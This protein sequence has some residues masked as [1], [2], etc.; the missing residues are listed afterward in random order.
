MRSH[1]AQLSRNGWRMWGGVTRNGREETGSKKK[2]REKN[3]ETLLASV[4]SIQSFSVGL[5]DPGRLPHYKLVAAARRSGTGRSAAARSSRGTAGRSGRSAAL[6]STDVAGRS[7]RSAAAR[8]RSAAGRGSRAAALGSAALRE[9][10]QAALRQTQ[11]ELRTAAINHTAG[12]PAANGATRSGAGRSSRG[13]ASRGSGCTAGRSGRSTAARRRGAAALLPERVDIRCDTTHH[14]SGS[15][16]HPL[17]S[18]HLLRIEIVGKARARGNLL[19]GGHHGQVKPGPN[20]LHGSHDRAWES[21]RRFRLA[22]LS[23]TT[24]FGPEQGS[25]PGVGPVVPSVS[26]LT[27]GPPTARLADGVQSPSRS[28]LSDTVCPGISF[29]IAVSLVTVLDLPRAGDPRAEI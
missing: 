10:R 18:G 19:Q 6:R 15:Q 5:F 26:F 20:R 2:T 29:G 28:V 16:G 25:I 23:L 3:P 22:A 1:A 13:T 4:T 9:L 8:S 24:G 11:L 7:G 21:H 12:I 27:R 14:H 17:H